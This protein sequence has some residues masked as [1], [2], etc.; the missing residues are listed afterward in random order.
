MALSGK[1]ISAGTAQPSFDY[2]DYASGLGYRTYYAVIADVSGAVTYFLSP[3]VMDT[4]EG[5]TLTTIAAPGTTTQTYDIT[6]QNP[7]IIQGNALVNFTFR[8]ATGEGNINPEF[9]HV[10]GGVE[11]LLGEAT[12]TNL[13]GG[14]INIRE[15]LLVS[16]TRQGFAVGD[17]L[18]LKYKITNV[19]GTI[20]AYHD[21]S[22][23]TTLTETTTGVTIQTSLIIKIPFVIDL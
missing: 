8:T 16:L 23:R 12:N 14:T 11:T 6:F 5:Y 1:Y 7:A 13:S 21:A 22:S 15:A 4:S 17:I 10:R 19:S 20:T 2:L 3:Q 18:R 9:Y